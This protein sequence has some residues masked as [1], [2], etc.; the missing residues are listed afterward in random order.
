MSLKKQIS[1]IG[2]IT[3]TLFFTIATLHAEDL[4]ARDIPK[5]NATQI[6]LMNFNSAS[7]QS[8]IES[9]D[10]LSKFA[11]EQSQVGSQDASMGFAAKSDEAKFFLIGSVYSEALAHLQGGD[12]QASAERLK[13]IETQLVVLQTPSSLYSYISKVRICIAQEKYEKEA[14]F[15]M[16][17]LFQP[18]FEDYAA[19]LSPDKVALFRAGSWLMDMGLTAAAKDKELIKQ[20]EPQL[21]YF[22]KEMTRMDAPKG[23]LKAY[24]EISK[25][26]AKDDIED[27]DVAKV[28]KQVKKIQIILG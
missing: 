6:D 16:L 3:L 19:G 23:V 17:S 11:Q 9:R 1:M 2:I 27:K 5:G 21:A 25:I 22:I 12:M 28:L 24:D 8:A 20:A 7:F 14:L 15:D 10:S 26:A 13:L 18:F 4:I